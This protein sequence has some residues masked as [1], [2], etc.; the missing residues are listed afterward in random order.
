MDAAVCQT[1]IAALEEPLQTLAKEKV[2]EDPDKTPEKYSKVISQVRSEQPHIFLNTDPN[3]I[4]RFL[5]L[6]KF[7]TEKASKQIIKFYEF[8]RDE[9]LCQNLL[10]SECEH[11]FNLGVGAIMPEYDKQQ[12]KLLILHIGQWN[13]NMV[14]LWDAFRTALLALEIIACDPAA[15]IT[16]FSVIVDFKDFSLKHLA[17]VKISLARTMVRTIQETVPVRVKALY[18]INASSVLTSLFATI[19]LL[20]SS[21]IRKRFHVLS[22]KHETENNDNWALLLEELGPEVLP[23]SLGGTAD[24]SHN[25]YQA[26][27]DL[28]LQ[29]EAYFKHLSQFGFKS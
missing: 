5:R 24:S 7:D 22:E 21:K 6:R 10:P 11:I 4:L 15:Q 28:M 12:R 19:K 8:Q 26:T 29:Q 25:P 23:A 17:H 18:F 16:G 9:P 27:C 2:Q 14:R 13:T 1:K 3:F 20:L